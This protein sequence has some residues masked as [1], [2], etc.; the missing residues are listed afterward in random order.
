LLARV[1]EGKCDLLVTGKHTEAIP[2]YEQV[3]QRLMRHAPCSVLI[4]RRVL[5]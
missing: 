4:A 1:H 2:E 5:A 3:G